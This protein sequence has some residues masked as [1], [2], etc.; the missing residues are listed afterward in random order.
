MSTEQIFHTGESRLNLG[1]SL[2]E[3]DIKS[4]ELARQIRE[5]YKN[6]IIGKANY[7]DRCKK[8]RYMDIILNRTNK[9]EKIWWKE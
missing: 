3:K 9:E 6:G 1:K 4:H 2:S 8:S 7:E 5:D